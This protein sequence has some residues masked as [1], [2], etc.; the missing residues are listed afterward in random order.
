M[1]TS[2]HLL[3]FGLAV[4]LLLPAA[5]LGTGGAPA[6][7]QDAPLAQSLGS[8]SFYD[9]VTQD[10][11]TDGASTDGTRLVAQMLESKPGSGRLIEAGLLSDV[12]GAQLCNNAFG[13]IIRIDFKTTSATDIV[14][15]PDGSKTDYGLEGS[16]ALMFGAARSA[17]PGGPVTLLNADIARSVAAKLGALGVNESGSFDQPCGG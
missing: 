4:L 3:C 11:R 7:A 9:N 15:W 1:S 6:R 16:F 8:W 17:G 12:K 10:T 14:Y 13:Y 5:T 2:R